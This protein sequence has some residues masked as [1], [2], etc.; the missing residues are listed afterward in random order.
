MSD[1]KLTAKQ[2]AFVREYLIDFN[3]TQAAIRAGYSQK[4]AEQVGYQQLQKTSVQKAIAEKQQ[5]R[6]LS[7]IRSAEDVLKDIQRVKDMAMKTRLT[8]AGD[9]VLINPNAA[10]KALELEGKH[11]AMFTEKQQVTGEIDQNIKITFGE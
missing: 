11:L 6:E 8:D 2:A 4:T 7:A 10:L 3:A 1:K 5:K 9:E